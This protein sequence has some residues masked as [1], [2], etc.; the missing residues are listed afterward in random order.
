MTSDN[1]KSCPCEFVE[2]EP[3]GKYCTCRMSHFS[4]GCDRCCKYGSHD[5]Q[6][7]AAKYLQSR[8]SRRTQ[9]KKVT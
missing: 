6:V 9:E 5:Q 2:V 3:C 8:L 4:G 7:E 1:R